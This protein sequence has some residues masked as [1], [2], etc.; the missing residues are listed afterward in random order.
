MSR[1]ILFGHLYSSVNWTTDDSFGRR[2]RHFSK[3]SRRSLRPN[4]PPTQ[5]GPREVCSP[6]AWVKQLWREDYLPLS[7][8]QV[9]SKWSYASV[10]LYAFMAYTHNRQFISSYRISFQSL[11][12]VHSIL[13]FRYTRTAFINLQVVNQMW[14]ALQFWEGHKTIIC[15]MILQHVC[16]FA[17]H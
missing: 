9:K 2:K 12:F 14:V 7:S 5:W 13:N 1:H 8:V 16:L 11:S 4:Q 3:T 6:S 17:F 15:M 10:T